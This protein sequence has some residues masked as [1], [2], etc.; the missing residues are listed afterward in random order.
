MQ[1][2]VFHLGKLGGALSPSEIRAKEDVEN[3]ATDSDVTGDGLD[4]TSFPLLRG[5]STDSC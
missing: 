5:S 3:R 4:F 2:T 1:N